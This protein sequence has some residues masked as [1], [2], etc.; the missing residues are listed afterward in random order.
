M[1]FTPVV[2][3]SHDLTIRKEVL[4]EGGEDSLGNG[5]AY[6]PGEPA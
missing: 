5:V 6:L 1:D 3:L 2:V 4:T